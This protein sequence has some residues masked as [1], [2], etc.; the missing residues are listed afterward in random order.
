MP[1][2]YRLDLLPL[3]V[4]QLERGPLALWQLIERSVHVQVPH[5]EDWSHA[6]QVNTP[7]DLERYL[8]RRA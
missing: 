4:E 8:G 3:V 7:A 6:V 1:A 2:L 5:P